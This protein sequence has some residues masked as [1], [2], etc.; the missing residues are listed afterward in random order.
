MCCA[1]CQNSGASSYGTYCITPISDSYFVRSADN[2]C[3][4]C[5]NSNYGITNCAKCIVSG[6]SLSCTLC[7]GGYYVSYQGGSSCTACT[8]INAHCA[9]CSYDSGSNPICLTTTNTLYYVDSSN[10]VKSCASYSGA[11]NTGSCCTNC[12]YNGIYAT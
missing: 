6:G 5:S 2:T 9:S 10:T 12:L 11:L 7:V 4:S 1:S 3:Y 8:S